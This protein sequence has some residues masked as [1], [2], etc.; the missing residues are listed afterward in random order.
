MIGKFPGIVLNKFNI[1]LLSTRLVSIT[2]WM[3][4]EDSNISTEKVTDLPIGYFGASTGAAAAIEASTT[5]TISIPHSNK[6]ML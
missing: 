5:T 3:I 2:N 6:Y 4:K 1:H